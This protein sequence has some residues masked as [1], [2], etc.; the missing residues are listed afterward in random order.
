M[1]ITAVSTKD[2][3]RAIGPYSQG[4]RAFDFVFCSGQIALDPDSGTLVEGD[5]AAQTRQVMENL[6][7]VIEE[8]GGKLSEVV[9]TTIFLTDMTAFPQVN[10]IY[11][12][13]FPTRPPA[14]STVGVA[15][16]PKGALVEIEAVV[17]VGG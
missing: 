17:Y 8:S 12:S 5:I 10:E 2:A 13:Y 3:P 4:I 11:G 9:K 6:K 16:L 7:A 14:R 1:A 15:S